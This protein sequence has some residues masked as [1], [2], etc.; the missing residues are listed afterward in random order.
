METFGSHY[1]VTATNDST[2]FP[3]KLDHTYFTSNA[4]LMGSDPEYTSIFIKSYYLS[5]FSQ[6]DKV[7]IKQLS[8]N[9]EYY[10]EYDHENYAPRIDQPNLQIPYGDSVIDYT[11]QGIFR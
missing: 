1:H 3:V 2:L 11:D 8:S 10:E 4:H 9:P 7:K 5:K 6:V